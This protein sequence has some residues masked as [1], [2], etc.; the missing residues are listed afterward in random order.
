MGS[1]ADSHEAMVKGRELGATK[2][3][4][5]VDAGISEKQA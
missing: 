4:I 3:T 2:V 1:Y 5:S